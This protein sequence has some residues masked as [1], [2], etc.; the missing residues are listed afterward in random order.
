MKVFN[1]LQFPRST[2]SV[3]RGYK[4][5][6]WTIGN[7]M[8]L[9][10]NRQERPKTC[11]FIYAKILCNTNNNGEL[12]KT[13]RRYSHTGCVLKTTLSGRTGPYD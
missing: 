3:H 2:S 7:E 11:S 1:Q 4:G 8:Q 5:C 12:K 9:D 6:L 10:V 13:T